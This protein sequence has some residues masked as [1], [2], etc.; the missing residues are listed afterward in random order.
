MKMRWMLLV[1]LAWAG[2][3]AHAQEVRTN[4]KG[5]KIIVYPDGSWRYFDEASEDPFGESQQQT[6]TELIP[7]DP[8]ERRAYEDRKS[9]EKAL[10]VADLATNRAT[11]ARKRYT[12][13]R[14]RRMELEASLK[15]LES[16]GK[17]ADRAEKQRTAQQ[18]KSA[19]KA[20]KAAY[21]DWQKALKFAAKAE[22]M[23]EAPYKKRSKWLAKVQQKDDELLAREEAPAFTQLDFGPPEQYASY[24]PTQD[25]MINPPPYQCQFTRDETD[26]FNG[27]RRKDLAAE[28][29]F[30]FT[31]PPLRTYMKGRTFIRCSASMT[32][33]SGGLIYLTF[34]FRVASPNA[35]KSFGGIPR[36]NF[37][38][39]RTLDGEQI[40][41]R[42]T[43]TDRGAYQA[44]DGSYTFRAQCTISAG[45]QDMLKR[46]EI[47]NMR[48]VW[49]TGYE[50]YQIYRIDF[51][52]DQL[53]C[54]L[55]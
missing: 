22:Q 8:D 52:K 26:P 48:V 23:V 17:T 49:Q 43:L 38:L 40:R 32:S 20:E 11:R 14:Q 2:A 44:S 33:V 54:L 31:P 29:L 51:F 25:P 10:R 35:H 19:Q 5:E 4:E 50:D 7:T 47:D 13:A 18:L 3:T 12:L 9:H 27:K 55:P 24:D 28:E 45:Q 21:K 1:L 34:I 37:I 16:L 15:H 39:L 41:L 42:N 46:S 30:A 6:P 53:N 36:G